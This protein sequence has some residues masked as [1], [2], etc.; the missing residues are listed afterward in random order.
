VRLN[1]S[2]SHSCRQSSW[3]FGGYGHKEERVLNVTAEEDDRAAA[4]ASVRVGLATAF[5]FLNIAED[6]RKSGCDDATALSVADAEDRY[7]DLVRF[8]SDAKTTK[9]VTASEWNDLAAALARLRPTLQVLKGPM[10]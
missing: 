4:L 10:I 3:K 9:Y 5:M 6:H 8:L 7:L 1:S 2:K